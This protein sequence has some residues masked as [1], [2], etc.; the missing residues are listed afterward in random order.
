MPTPWT[1]PSAINVTG[2]ANGL[3]QLTAVGPKS[4]THDDNGNVTA[5]GTDTFAYSSENLLLTG[6]GSTTLGYDPLL[7]LYQANSGG[8]TQRFAYDGLDMIAEYNGAGALQRRYV[9]GPGVDEPLVQYEGSGTTDRR[10]LHAD[11][12]GS[13]VAISN[14]SG[15]MLNINKYDEYG[16]PGS[17]NAGR[18]QYTGQ[19]W[20]GEVDAYYYK[21]R[22]YSPFAGGRFLQTDP[23]GYAGGLNLYAYVG[24]DPVNFTDS[25]GL[26]G[27]GD[28][29]VVGDCDA[30]C[31][32]FLRREAGWLD[33]FLNR[34]P[35]TGPVSG[36][37]AGDGG[38]V[39]GGNQQCPVEPGTSASSREQAAL[40][41]ARWERAQQNAARDNNERSFGI[42]PL[43]SGGS[44]FYHG[45]MGDETE[46][47]IPIRPGAT[48][49]GHLHTVGGGNRLSRRLDRYDK[50]R[51]YEQFMDVA[52]KNKDFMTVLVG[53]NGCVHMV[54]HKPLSGRQ[55]Y[56]N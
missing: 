4:L 34:G 41:A 20:L 22:F 45:F 9:F 16:T 52:K 40:D 55:N 29:T 19:M 5:F 38:S 12:R 6:P 53:E 32:A 21:A 46:V 51:D 43:T 37:A 13:I 7:R 8:S 49:A 42:V 47:D 15:A 24:N 11:E 17:S 54:W 44:T 50:K 31:R 18:F 26:D 27:E 25:L 30:I 28:I 3:N 48:G 33:N 39:D 36:S 56:R 2:T 10:F 1:G 35:T 23:I 14:A